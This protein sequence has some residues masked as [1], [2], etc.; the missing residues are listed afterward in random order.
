MSTYRRWVWAD[1][2]TEE[3]MTSAANKGAVERF[4]REARGLFDSIPDPADRDDRANDGFEDYLASLNEE[5]PGAAD[6][7]LAKRAAETAAKWGEIEALEEMMSA[8]GA[9][10]ARDYEHHNEDEGRMEWAERNRDEYP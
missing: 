9:R 1:D 2:A 8:R 4:A 10:F 5:E 6:R 3:Q 7:Y